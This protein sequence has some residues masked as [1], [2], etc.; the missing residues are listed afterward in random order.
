MKCVYC[1]GIMKSGTAPVHIDR[2]GYHFMLDEAPAYV[3]RQCGKVYFEESE[4]EAIQKVI[5]A[6]DEQVEKIAVPAA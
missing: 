5:R 2:K 4:V 6:I 3:C 1:Q